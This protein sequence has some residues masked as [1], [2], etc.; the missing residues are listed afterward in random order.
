MPSDYSALESL[1]LFQYLYSYGSILPTAFTRLSDQLKSDPNIRAAPKYDASRFTPDALRDFF[2]SI[3]NDEAKRSSSSTSDPDATNGSSAQNSKKRKAPTPPLPSLQ[4][5]TNNLHLVPQ[6][7]LRLYSQFRQQTVEE[8]R[9]DERLYEKYRQE[10]LEIERGEWDERLQKGLEE[11][12]KRRFPGL[13]SNGDQRA[14]ISP[15]APK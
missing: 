12:E 5:A 4:D 13:R 9:E 2:L 8:I 1:L 10:V 14:S 7:I 3:L 15:T 11:Q 6:L